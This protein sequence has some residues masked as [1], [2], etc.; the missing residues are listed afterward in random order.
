MGEGVKIVY[1]P[2]SC[3][4]LEEYETL[5]FIQMP[6]VGWIKWLCNCY[7]CTFLGLG[8]AGFCYWRTSSQ[9]FLKIVWYVSEVKIFKLDQRI[10]FVP[11]GINQL[12]F[13]YADAGS[14]VVAVVQIGLLKWNGCVRHSVMEWI[15]YDGPVVNILIFLFRVMVERFEAVAEDCVDRNRFVIHVGPVTANDGPKGW[16]LLTTAAVVKK[17]LVVKQKYADG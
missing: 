2:C 13:L 15:A 17:I 6:R 14:C 5:W 7:C 3:F 11:V 16:H 8:Y 4:L 1:Q 10:P 12:V 9:L